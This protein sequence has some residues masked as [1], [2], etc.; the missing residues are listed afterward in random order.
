MNIKETRACLILGDITIHAT[1]THE[2]LI[3]DAYDKDDDIIDTVFKL[4]S[5]QDEEFEVLP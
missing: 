3:I 5:E 2:G 1:C 4:H